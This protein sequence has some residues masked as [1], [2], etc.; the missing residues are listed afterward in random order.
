MRRLLDAHGLVARRIAGQNFV[1]DPNTVRKVVRDAGVGPRDTVL[2]P[3]AGLGSLTLALAEVAARVVA[4]EV[5]V[6]LVRALRETVGD[7][8]NVEIVHDDALVADPDALVGGR[9][10]R[11][12][13]NL[14][15]RLATPLVLHALAGHAVDD[16]FVMVQREVGE[17]WAATRGDEPYSGVS[18]KL[19]L[20]ATA[21][22]VA[23][24][25]RTVFLPQPRVDSVTVRLRRRPDALPPDERER[26]ATVVDAAFH[27][28]RKTLRRSLSSLAPPDVVHAAVSRAGV[29]PG[30]RPERLDAATFVR[31]AGALDAESGGALSTLPPT[32]SRRTRGGV[33]EPTS[34]P[35][36]GAT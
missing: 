10:A 22:V 4:V 23:R 8:D 2:E 26:V 36:R 14:P 27:Q 5:D 25:P 21:E 19:A 12:V 31:L 32:R 34:S 24:V 28:R 20:V 30:E 11:L 3:G 35:R 33:R 15:Y 17:R 1:V 9:P 29:D 6:G 7:R 13:A 16:V 18:V